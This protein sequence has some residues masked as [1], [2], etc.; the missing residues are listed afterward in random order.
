[1]WGSKRFAHLLGPGRIGAIRTKNR[2]MK[3]GTHN[4]YDTA[5]G[6]QNQRNIDF[7]DT[8]A[9]G[10]VGLIV[11]ASAPLVP[12]AR[13][14]RLD[15]DEFISGFTRLADTIHKHDCPAMVQLFHVGPMSPPF[16]EGPQ[17]VAASSIPRHESP[18]PQ[19]AQARAL[20][21]PEIEDIT[22]RFC[23]ASER[24]KKAGFQGVELNAATNHLLNSFLSRAWNRR[25]DVYGFATM[26]G[27]TKVL[28]DIVSEIKRRNGR[29]FAVISLI[30]GAEVGLKDGI[31]SEESREIAQI[32]E[33]A[34]ADAIEVRAEYYSWTDDD[35]IRES[36]HFPDIYFYPETPYPSGSGADE[37]HHG[38]GANVPLAAAI[39][40]VVSVPVITVGRLDAGLGEKAIRLGR[41]DFVSLNRRLLADPE[42]PKKI[43]A[44]RLED[45]APC[46]ACISCFNLG[47]HGRPVEC[48]INAAL[49][50]E[51]EYEIKPALRKKRVVIIG[52]GPAGMEAARVAAL[53]GHE[54]SLYEKEHWLGGSLPLAAVV[55]GSERED[56]VSIVRYLRRQIINLGV[57]VHLGTEAD[58]S[59]IEQ[60]RPD[61]V[62]VATGG[63]HKA[64]NLPGIDGPNVVTGPDLHKR[65]KA[66]VA[67]FGPRLLRWLT[68]FYMPL[69]KRVII[70][71]GGVHG[72]QVAEF[73][74]KRGRQVTIV[75]EAETIGHGLLDVLV[76]PY[77]LHWLTRKGVAML[78][79]VRYERITDRGLE[80]TTKEGKE[81]TLY[82]ETIVTANP[83]VA[84]TRL[85]RALKG[86]AAEVYAVGD[87]R[88]PAMIIDAVA[89]G[90]RTGR[91]I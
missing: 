49:G 47:E 31:T 28:V 84:E 25:Q 81:T 12:D 24:A 26:E 5:D 77:L 55:K 42:L 88:E 23:A 6:I 37:A 52:G 68:I 14:Y 16:F 41:I 56:L 58:R 74:A 67:V 59:L 54:V 66:Y 27:R 13:G 17:P 35:R 30:N 50:R 38:A 33:K 18:R 46:T 48:R 21:I 60:A 22:E 71:G 65:L 51:R 90:S 91:V 40:E 79:G 11:V 72:C 10:G 64:P 8:L 53:R 82:A 1:M 69:G 87:A 32:V 80:L 70:M 44:G 15:S 78:A 83:L 29:D 20:T 45:I 3:N 57:K 43:A 2:I 76:G 4:F 73:L 89:D 39:K 62:V 85:I 7:Y 86:V 36:T 34:G 19:W 75:D 61:V 9:R 63:S